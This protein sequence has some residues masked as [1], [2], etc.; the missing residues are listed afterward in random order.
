M[1]GR[2]RFGALVSQRFIVTDMKPHGC[3]KGFGFRALWS[4]R[5]VR[6][7]VDDVTNQVRGTVAGEIAPQPDI[8]V[9]RR[10]RVGGTDGDSISRG[11][12][13][14]CLGVRDRLI[15]I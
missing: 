11:Q 2:N 13:R 14:L 8:T 4:I 12:C 5:R 15:E 3:G 9:R 1:I 6:F 10:N 7:A